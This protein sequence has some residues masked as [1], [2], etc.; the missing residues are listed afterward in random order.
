[1]DPFDDVGVFPSCL[2]FTVVNHGSRYY[3]S[4]NGSVLC[5][6]GSVPAVRA[7]K[8]RTCIHTSLK[9]RSSVLAQST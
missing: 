1:M 8:G 6:S 9:A 4:S 2:F 7:V 3:Q 5:A